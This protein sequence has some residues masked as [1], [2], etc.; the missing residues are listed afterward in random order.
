[1][2]L[3]CP[4]KLYRMLPF[5]L[6][7]TQQE[8]EELSLCREKKE[9]QLLLLSCS[10][11]P[12]GFLQSHLWKNRSNF[13]GQLSNTSAL[14]IQA[15][16]TSWTTSQWSVTGCHF[17]ARVQHCFPIRGWTRRPEL[18]FHTTTSSGTNPVL[19]S[20]HHHDCAGVC[21]YRGPAH[22]RNLQHG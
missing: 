9:Q 15:S 13:S 21:D 3:D 14:K 2:N 20:S 12:L 8:P 17:L 11:R 10:K 19:I 6:I 22:L 16:Q 1:M 4:R 5:G 18:Q 7:E